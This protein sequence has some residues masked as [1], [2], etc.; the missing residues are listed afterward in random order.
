MPPLRALLALALFAIFIGA[1]ASEGVGQ[2]VARPWHVVILNAADFLI[3]FWV[4]ID[5][6]LRESITEAAAPHEVDFLGEA[7][8]LVRFPELEDE[9]IPL[10]KKK[11]SEQPIDLV[12]AVGPPALEFAKKYQDTIWRGAPIVFVVVPAGAIADQSRPANFTGVYYDIDV[13]GTLALMARLQPQWNRLLV[14]GGNSAFDLALNVRLLP[15]DEHVPKRVAVEYVN[16]RTPDELAAL[17]AKLPASAAVLY[18]SM[19][20][21]A[22]GATHAPREIA[23]RLARASSAPVYAHVSADARAGHRRRLDGLDRR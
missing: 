9:Q 23:G 8:D 19:T 4:T 14:V 1:H 12:I 20:R 10:L 5:P 11:Y 16:D 17:L 7:L 22:S 15:H 21:D 6:V 3:P 13:D 2:S 18:T